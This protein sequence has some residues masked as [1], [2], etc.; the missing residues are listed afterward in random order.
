MCTKI[1]SSKEIPDEVLQLYLLLASYTRDQSSLFMVHMLQLPTIDDTDATK[2][3]IVTVEQ[4]RDMLAW[5]LGLLGFTECSK[6]S[7]GV[8]IELQDWVHML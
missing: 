5:N 3:A 4:P 2:G 1:C 6:P 8:G 7:T